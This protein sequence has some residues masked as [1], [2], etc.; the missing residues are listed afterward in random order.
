[1]MATKI[2]LW[3]AIFLM[4]YL[5][6]SLLFKTPLQNQALTK[7]YPFVILPGFGNDQLDYV[8]PNGQGEDY[9]LQNVLLSKGIQNVEVVPIK[10]QNWLIIAKGLWNIDFWAS[11]CKPEILFDFYFR[12]V[13]KKVSDVK[14]QTGKPVVLICHSAGGWLARALLADGLWRGSNDGIISSDLVAGI[15]TLGSPHFPPFPGTSDMTRGAI[16]YVDSMYPGAYLKNKQG[17]FYI[18]VA[19]TAVS[20]DSSAPKHSP[21][22]FAARSYLQVTGNSANK[23]EELGDGVVPISSAHLEG[24]QQITLE[25]CWHSIN[26]PGNQW[27]G[28]PAMV[29]LWLP[30]VFKCLDMQH[31]MGRPG[32]VVQT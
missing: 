11:R 14:Q 29:D 30:Q 24:A 12:S 8:N 7:S 20:G 18:T 3:V 16:A 17:I 21:E 28:Q 10:R 15:V 31:R 27:Y 4:P 2:L 25:G 6:G 26:A 5:A 32:D 23:G 22:N 13:H 19:G 1:M 9:G